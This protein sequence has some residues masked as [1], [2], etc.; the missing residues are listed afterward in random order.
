MANGLTAFGTDGFTVGIDTNYSDTTGTG[1]AAWSWLGGGTGVAN[2][3]GTMDSTVSANPT[4]GFSIV[5]YEGQSN[6]A[7]NGHNWTRII[8]DSRY[9]NSK[10]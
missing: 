5:S 1:M 3:T 2:T 8:S 10:R 9:V 6:S 7:T 4:A